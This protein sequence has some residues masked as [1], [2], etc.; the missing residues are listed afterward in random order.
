MSIARKRNNCSSL[1]SLYFQSN[2]NGVG[3][4]SHRKNVHHT[5]RR[6]SSSC[7]PHSCTHTLSLAN[8]GISS[9]VTCHAF[10]SIRHQHAISAKVSFGAIGRPGVSTKKRC[11]RIGCL[12]G[13]EGNDVRRP[14]AVITRYNR[15]YSGCLQML[16]IEYIFHFL[17]HIVNS[18]ILA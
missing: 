17:P 15:V 1:I 4:C 12:A 14:S 2:H 16:L 3:W 6:P 11:P 10:A 18:I 13:L 8:H 9:V 5:V 7:T